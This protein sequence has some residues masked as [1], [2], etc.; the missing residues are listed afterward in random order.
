MG[1]KAKKIFRRIPFLGGR[2]FLHP[3]P[4]Q[5]YNYFLQFQQMEQNFLKNILS[6]IR[7]ELTEE[8][9]RN[10]ERKAFFDRPWD[11]VKI[12]NKRGS[13]MMRTGKLRRSI[14]SQIMADAIR[15]TSSLPYA[16][17]QNEGGTIVVTR[18]M[19]KFFWAMYYSLAG[20]MVYSVKTKSATNTKRNKALTVEAQYW[21]AMALKKVGSRIII[22]SRRFI[23]AHTQVDIL[24]TKV[25]DSN[26]KELDNY[27]KDKF[28]SKNFKT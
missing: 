17:I 9:D 3:Q 28:I 7:V 18:K 12:P 26:F 4:I 6:D 16:N 5:R 24:V 22:R 11:E 13:L 10:F 23:G 20:R 14:R 25:C 2:E 21:K 27:I 15:F 19:Q 1:Y 8:F